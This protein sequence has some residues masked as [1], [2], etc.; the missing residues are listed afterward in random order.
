MQIIETSNKYGISQELL[1]ISILSK[2]GT[3]SLPY[4][5]SARYDCILEIEKKFYTIQIKSLNIKGDNDSI[6][7]PM[8]NCNP[9]TGKSKEYTSD[10]I[11]F[12]AISFNNKVYLFPPDMSKRVITVRINKP[13]IIS[14]HWI[15]DYYIEKVLDIQLETW[16]SQKEKNREQMS[17]LEKK[18]KRNNKIYSCI[19]CGQPCSQE[20]SLCIECY[21]KKISLTSK[22]PTKE[23]LKEHLI[24]KETFVSIGKQYGVTDNAV[25]KWCRSYHLPSKT[26]ELKTMT[27]EEISQL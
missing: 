24:K 11:D 4:G 5:N 6:T 3:V 7:I 20:N 15:E 19:E 26:S 12:I 2:Y 21:R 22:K 16:T 8:A 13:N 17:S 14:Q 23:K 25:R 9:I 18:D 1:T 10:Q 27:E